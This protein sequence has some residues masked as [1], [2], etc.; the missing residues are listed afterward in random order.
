MGDVKVGGFYFGEFLKLETGLWCERFPPKC[1][2]PPAE[3]MALSQ[4][5]F[6]DAGG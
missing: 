4:E 2:V 1:N 6:G 3:H 5:L